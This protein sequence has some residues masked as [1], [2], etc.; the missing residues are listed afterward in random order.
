MPRQSAAKARAA[1]DA[2]ESGPVCADLNDARRRN[3]DALDACVDP[4]E[5]MMNRGK[6]EIY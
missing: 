2:R 6:V 4:R 1:K 5:K 3:H